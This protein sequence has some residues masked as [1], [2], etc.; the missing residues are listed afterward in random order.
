MHIDES[1]FENSPQVLPNQGVAIDEKHASITVVVP[2]LQSDGPDV[3]NSS[4]RVEGDIKSSVDIPMEL[5]KTE[6]SPS[7]RLSGK[8]PSGVEVIRPKTEQEKFGAG[9]S[10]FEDGRGNIIIDP[11]I[12]PKGRLKSGG[13]TP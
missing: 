10:G 11:V 7:I 6:A 9:Y 3:K 5:S 1:D 13:Y 2:S 4:S 12:K 8:D